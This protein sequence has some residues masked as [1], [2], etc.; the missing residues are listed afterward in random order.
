MAGERRL[1]RLLDTLAPQTFCWD[2]CGLIP[3]PATARCVSLFND[4][5]RSYLTQ[6]N[7][8][9]IPLVSGLQ[10]L[11]EAL[12]L[13]D[14]PTIV[15]PRSHWDHPRQ[16]AAERLSWLGP[17]SDTLAYV[18][19]DD[20]A[21]LD[22]APDIMPTVLALTPAALRSRAEFV[23]SER[24]V[25][26]QPWVVAA[27]IRGAK[28]S[29]MALEAAEDGPPV[30]CVSRRLEGGVATFGIDEAGEM[31]A[32]LEL[33]ETAV[34]RAACDETGMMLW[35]APDSTDL[36]L[37]AVMHSSQI[38]GI[39]LG[40]LQRRVADMRAQVARMYQPG[41]SVLDSDL[42]C[43]ITVGPV[44]LALLRE[45]RDAADIIRVARQFRE[46][47]LPFRHH[48]ALLRERSREEASLEWLYDW[49][50]D[51]QRVCDAV[52]RQ[53]GIHPLGSGDV[54]SIVLNL[55]QAKIGEA[56]AGLA[57]LAGRV[58]APTRRRL[59]RSYWLTRWQAFLRDL[60]YGAAVAPD[61]D[62]E[63]LR[64]FG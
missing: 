18:A 9:S 37:L 1:C 33:F 56:V 42:H 22:M 11:L 12:V 47:A 51:L 58:P 26:L 63:L 25:R 28:E 27:S 14:R 43:S 50:L 39:T 20:A 7:R 16:F 2:E 61:V 62:R 64:L 46:C 31:A 13:S 23:R 29:A 53:L 3:P 24:S 34:A 17:A 15:L 49:R 32:A 48:L 8:P 35:A 5:I 6:E 36:H 21:L 55:A 4:G 52:A 40:E 41:F 54:G 38:A 59:L 57:A 10:S 30:L 60:V 19:L 44:L 45:A